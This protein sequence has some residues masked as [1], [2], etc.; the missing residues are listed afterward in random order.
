MGLLGDEDSV[1]STVFAVVALDAALLCLCLGLCTVGFAD[2]CGTSPLL[3]LLTGE[4]VLQR[5]IASWRA[6]AGSSSSSSKRTAFDVRCLF[7]GGEAM[8]NDGRTKKGK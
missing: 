4:A 1:L 8:H 7:A 2:C 5:D 6:T 3:M